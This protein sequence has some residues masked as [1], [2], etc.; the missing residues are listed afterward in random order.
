[1][2]DVFHF[3]L[4]WGLSDNPCAVWLSLFS[5]VIVVGGLTSL[6]KDHKN[7]AHDKEKQR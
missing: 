7:E 4:F 6:G 5:F 1:M 3:V 2:N